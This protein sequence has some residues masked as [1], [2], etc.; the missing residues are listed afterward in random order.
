MH[1]VLDRSQFSA[2]AKRL[3]LPG[4][5]GADPEAHIPWLVEA[6]RH[7]VEVY[8][9]IL[10]KAVACKA[11]ATATTMAVAGLDALPKVDLPVY[12]CEA[13][14]LLENCRRSSNGGGG[15]LHKYDRRFSA[16]YKEREISFVLLTPKH[17]ATLQDW[18]SRRGYI[19]V[20][21]NHQLTPFGPLNASFVGEWTGG[22][23]SLN[24]K[25]RVFFRELVGEE[26]YRINQPVDMDRSLTSYPDETVPWDLEML[27]RGHPN[28]EECLIVGV[29]TGSRRGR[30][31]W[32]DW[33]QES[34][35][36]I[37]LKRAPRPRD[38]EESEDDSDW[39]SKR[40]R[41]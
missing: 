35:T 30:E 25:R 15:K 1:R 8:E 12:S 20:P 16:L 2:L 14:L 18:Y 39:D 33:P 21:L 6:V 17:A 24:A 3:R 5:A 22:N 27:F 32:L 13:G 7:S 28:T 4:G 38:D 19:I 9:A 34:V 10:T 23:Y 36:D 37:S 40:V 41:R 11:T 26:E 29:S 31:G